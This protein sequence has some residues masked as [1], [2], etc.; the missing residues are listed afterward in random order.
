MRVVEY[1]EMGY[2]DKVSLA[3]GMA[4][5]GT[6]ITAA[7]VRYVALLWGR[8]KCACLRPV[9]PSPPRRL[10]ETR[11]AEPVA[12]GRRFAALLEA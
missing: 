2:S 3:R 7:G 5:T 1:R 10:C 11:P 4:S 8:G 9:F 12:A 6:I